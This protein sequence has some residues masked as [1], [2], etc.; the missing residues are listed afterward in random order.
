MYL[1]ELRIRNYR[2]FA[3]ETIQFRPGVNVLLGENNAGKTT[4]IKALGLV[5]EQKARRRPK[6]FDFHHP[7]VDLTLPPA[8]AI[9]VTFRSSETDTVEDKALMATWLTKLES[10][11]EAQITY[12]FHLEP[13]QQEDC[14]T[15]LANIPANSFS[16]YRR[17]I[18][19]YL[20][21]Y[22][23][24]IYGG[25]FENRLEA[26]YESLNKITLHTLD[27]LRDAGKE[28][29]SGTDPLLKRLLKQVRDLGKTSAEKAASTQ[30]LRRLTRALGT[31]ICGRLSL[32]PLLQLV[33]D[34]GALEGGRPQL[35]DDLN[36]EDLLFAL[37]LYVEAGGIQ[38]P[39]EL[40]GLGYINL[41]Y[42][43]LVLASLDHQSDPAKLGPNASIFPMLTIEE[44]EAH[45]HPA[46]QYKLL[47]HIEKRVRETKRNRQV[48]ITTH[49]THITSAS[50][51]D[52]LIVCTIPAAPGAPRIAYPGKCFS[53]DNQGKASKAY[54]ERYLD[55]TK[56]NLLFA[57]GVILVEGIAE[58]LLIPV[59]AEHQNCPL[60]EHHV[61][62]IPVGGLTFKHFLPLFGAGLTQEQARNALTRPVACLVDAD[63]TRKPAAT[64]E[65]FQKCYPYELNREPEYAYRPISSAVATLE[66]LATGRANVRVEHGIMTLEYDLALANPS[67]ALLVTNACTHA[68]PLRTL[69]TD[70]AATPPELEPPLM[71]A[72]AN[73]THLDLLDQTAHIFATCYLDCIENSK[74]EHALSLA[75]AIKD[76][77]D[78]PEIVGFTVPSAIVRVVRWACRQVEA[79]PATLPAA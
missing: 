13:D 25:C 46:L 48:F 16:E 66:T 20:D 54:V 1:A 4:I 34:T 3:D 67:S 32:D 41:L 73:T 50:P 72:R 23:A 56:S 68:E 77:K 37:R 52:Q 22:V 44:P 14:R 49:S 26:E 9:T 27:A 28:L 64:S 12:T 43:S 19:S 59:L 70:P 5:M 2:C 42:M 45:L 8:I 47:K 79:A 60:E 40:N 36:E 24:K 18:D 6:F 21:M 63:P 51:L 53:T 76:A 30:E 65:K 38:I 71:R 10:P 31:H 35:A 58:Q 57:K 17:V 29:F 55:A 78:S 61:A 74:G 39:A 33:N 62:L 15:A 7:C 11:W 75:S 69:I